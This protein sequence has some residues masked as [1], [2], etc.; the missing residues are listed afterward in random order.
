MEATRMQDKLDPLHVLSSA[1]AISSIG[2]LAALLR[3]KQPLSL[4]TTVAAILYSGIVGLLIALLWFNYFK[5]SDENLYF[6]LGISGLAGIGGTTVIDLAVQILRN[7][8]VNIVIKP[9]DDE[10]KPQ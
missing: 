6:L 10:D 1:F 9:N 2:G 4:R 7:G 8:G 3:S 5:S